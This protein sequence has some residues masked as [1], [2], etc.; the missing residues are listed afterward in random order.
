ML[1][2][3]AVGLIFLVLAK[4]LT[5]GSHKGVFLVP[6]FEKSSDVYDLLQVA[7]VS[8]GI[9]GVAV[10]AFAVSITSPLESITQP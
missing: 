8:Q 3:A 2:L 4:R 5:V 10:E 7:G 1:F 9:S 6:G